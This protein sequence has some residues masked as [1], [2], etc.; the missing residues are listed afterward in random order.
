[1]CHTYVRNASR[2]CHKGVTLVTK[3]PHTSYLNV[4]HVTR[5]L[6]GDVDQDV[7]LR[8]QGAQVS[9][10]CHKGVTQVSQGAMDVSHKGV[11]HL[12]PGMYH[13][14]HGSR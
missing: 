13:K 6:T 10:M 5:G 7:Q 2:T 12:R 11:T 3:V 9:H 8:Q 4:L 1:M 14:P